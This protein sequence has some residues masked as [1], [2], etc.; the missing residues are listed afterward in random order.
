MQK[1]HYFLDE[2]GDPVF[3]GKGRR[4]IIGEQGVSSHF[5]LGM[6]SFREDLHTIRTRILA[7]QQEVLASPYF[8]GIASIEKKKA[9][10]GYFFHATDDIPEIRKLFYDFIKTLDCSFEA[11]VAAKVPDAHCPAHGGNGSNEFY[12]TLLSHLLHRH[13]PAAHRLVLNIARRAA[14]TRHENLAAGLQKAVLLFQ[15][16]SPEVCITPDVVF[17][18]QDQLDEPL[19]NIADYLCWSLQRV[20]EK[21]EKR[22]YHYVMDKFSMIIHLYHNGIPGG[23]RR[24]GQEELLTTGHKKSPSTT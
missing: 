10:Y 17:N 16:D 8:E 18:V 7:L 1:R 22:F 20:Y 4:I 5:I 2:A 3:Y 14:S 15:A 21:G 9:Q 12:A 13:V 23:I 19:L 11:V 6:V 24:L